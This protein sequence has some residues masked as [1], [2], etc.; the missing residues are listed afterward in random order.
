MNLV[1]SWDVPTEPISVIT[2][3]APPAVAATA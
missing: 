1:A 3:E 2:P